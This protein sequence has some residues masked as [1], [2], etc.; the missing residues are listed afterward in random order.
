MGIVE[1]TVK[2]V[3]MKKGMRENVNWFERQVILLNHLQP[4]VNVLIQSLCHHHLHQKDEKV[5]VHNNQVNVHA[6]V[7]NVQLQKWNHS[8][9]IL[10]PSVLLKDL[11]PKSVLI[12]LVQTKM[13]NKNRHRRG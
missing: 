9:E 13:L 2:E 1:T 11:I 3:V 4:N 6:A 12:S 8:S 7:L 5:Q 10:V